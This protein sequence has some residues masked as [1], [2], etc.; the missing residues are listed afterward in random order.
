[1]LSSVTPRRCRNLAVWAC[2]AVAGCGDGGDG[3]GGSAGSGAQQ[4]QL[5][6]DLRLSLSPGNAIDLDYGAVGQGSF[7]AKITALPRGATLFI[8]M[9]DGLHKDVHCT[10]GEGMPG[11][12]NM[13]LGAD[14]VA[15]E[16]M[17]ENMGEEAIEFRAMVNR[18]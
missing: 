9:H 14:G 5:G 1:M 7:F 4:V 6:Q 10:L 16:V 3:G 12:C 11:P 2:L 17:L 8:R 13:D 15:L 18:R